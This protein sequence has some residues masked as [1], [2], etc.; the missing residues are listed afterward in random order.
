MAIGL[1]Q[2]IRA[3][4]SLPMAD[5]T[6]PLSQ[7]SKENEPPPSSPPPAHTL[8]S[9]ALP[10]YKSLSGSRPKRPPTITPRTFTRFFTPKSLSIKQ[11][12][13]ASRR[14]LRQITASA[15]NSRAQQPRIRLY[16]AAESSQNVEDAGSRAPKSR[17][18]NPSSPVQSP[19]VSSPIRIASS[20]RP[21]KC[22]KWDEDVVVEDEK[23]GTARSSQASL[24]RASLG[25]QTEGLHRSLYGP[26]KGSFTHSQPRKKSERWQ[27]ETSR[28]FSEPEDI[29]VCDR[30]PGESPGRSMPYC[31]EPCNTNTLVAIGD[32]NG[33]VRLLESS[34]ESPAWSQPILKAQKHTN[35]VLDMSFS[36]D[37]LLLATA[38]GDQTTNITDMMA[39]KTL[40]T[41]SGHTSSAKQVKFQPNSSSIL[42]T[43]SRDGSIQLY[44]LRVRG[45]DT[46]IRSFK[47]SLDPSHNPPTSKYP[48]L[49]PINAMYEAHKPSHL[50]T[51]TLYSGANRHS[52]PQASL[53]PVQSSSNPSQN[54]SEHSVTALLF[55]PLHP[56]LLIS[57]SASSASLS[58]WDIRTTHSRRSRPPVPLSIVPSPPS[59]LSSKRRYGLTSLSLS[60]KGDKLYTLCRDNTVYVYATSHLVLGSAPEFGGHSRVKHYGNA[61]PRNG[62]GPLHGFRHPLLYASSFYVK[63]SL[64]RSEGANSECLAV[65]SNT[66]T[67]ILF[68]TDEEVLSQQSWESERNDVQSTARPGL[69]RQNTGWGQEGKDDEVPI[70]DSGTALVGGHDCEVT[71]VCW[72]KGG[73][74]VS[75]SDDQTA[76]LW[77][78]GERARELRVE[79][80]GEGR[81]WRCGWAE[82]TEDWDDE[83]C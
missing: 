70:Y 65:G 47:V 17:R 66:G 49:Q 76:R 59:H 51:S 40:Y 32:E 45:L 39:H 14:A 77:R 16:D 68:P 79:G 38:S 41:L 34:D 26:V 74:L 10:A 23:S 27:H 55:L 64:R 21:I 37:D 28:F 31:V 53:E 36:P 48:Y 25:Q 69:R 46:P 1:N 35:A 33:V 19:D 44:D 6:P 8:S 80:E 29:H 2:A 82:V 67:P 81:R 11:K 20:S 60:T 61:A 15:A 58:I 57:G 56:H 43:S 24:H 9:P 52:A 78:E 62:L 4:F 5:I 83:D 3:L 73:R 72:S 42:A 7:A 13:G 18:L 63:T 54:Q 22:E 30:L 50:P 75:V 12:P 71:G